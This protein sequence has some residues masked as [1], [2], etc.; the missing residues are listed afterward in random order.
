LNELFADNE[1]RLKS[2][3]LL[4]EKLEKMRTDKGASPEPSETAYNGNN[5]VGDTF[6]IET[7]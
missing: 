4:Q 6:A 7:I 5:L 1:E 3:Q 2:D